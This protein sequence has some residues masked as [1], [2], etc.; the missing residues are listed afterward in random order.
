VHSRGGTG[1]DG[2][3]TNTAAVRLEPRVE[4]LIQA[5]GSLNRLMQT[6]IDHVS[7]L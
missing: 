5:Y 2:G 7:A 4:A 1:M 3:D 6:F